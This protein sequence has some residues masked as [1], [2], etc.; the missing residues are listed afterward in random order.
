MSRINPEVLRDERARRGWSLERLASR[1]GINAQSIHRI[2]KGGK[3]NNRRDV[4]TRLAEA[5]GIPEDKL[6]GSGTASP[7][8]A[9]TEETEE[10]NEL[11]LES[12]LNLRVSN[13]TRNAFPFIAHRYGVSHAQIVEI[14]PFLFCWAAEQS[15]RR[16][17]E[18]LAEFDRKYAELWEF[19]PHHLDARAFAL[20]SDVLNAEHESAEANDLFG[21]TLQ[22]QDD[23]LPKKYSEGTDNPFAVFLRELAGELGELATFAEWEPNSSPEYTLCRPTVID[24]VAGDVEATDKILEGFVSL[25]RLPK[26][27]REE[28]KGEARAKWVRD[29]AAARQKKR[30][31]L[32]TLPDLGI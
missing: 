8:P 20:R 29:E 6:T 25:H 23:C 18:R 4:I 14:A 32:L 1:S 17:R 22:S 12:Q 28:G 31:E 2:E 9:V 11:F 24:Y 26:E 27:L 19:K 16:R 3:K 5:L 7:P 21:Q 30:S 10:I 15:L 13:R